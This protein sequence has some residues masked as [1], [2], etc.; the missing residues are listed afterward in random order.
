MSFTGVEENENLKK[1]F[2]IARDKFSQLMNKNKAEGVWIGKHEHSKD[3]I[4]GFKWSE[5]PIKALGVYFGNNKEDCEQLN[6]EHKIDKINTLFI[7]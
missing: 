1:K 2:S 7:S 5:K 6:W 4:E 3:K